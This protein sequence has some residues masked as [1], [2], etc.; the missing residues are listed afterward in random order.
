MCIR[1]RLKDLLDEN[2]EYLLVIRLGLEKDREAYYYTC[3]LYTSR[4]GAFRRGSASGQRKA[5]G[6]I[7]SSG[8]NPKY[9]GRGGLSLYGSGGQL[10]CAGR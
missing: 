9:F 5:A 3:L 7:H 4:G 1:D 10:F 2:E 8:K 6:D